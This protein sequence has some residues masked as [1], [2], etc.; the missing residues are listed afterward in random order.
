VSP[1]SIVVKI[2][3]LDLATMVEMAM[4]VAELAA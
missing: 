3:L 1:K 4:Y 2:S